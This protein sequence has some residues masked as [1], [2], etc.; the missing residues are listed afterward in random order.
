MN[1][2]SSDA[3]PLGQSLYGLR[4]P[5]S[6]LRVNAIFHYEPATKCTLCQEQV[7]VP[8]DVQV[9]ACRATEWTPQT[10]SQLQCNGR[11]EKSPPMETRNTGLAMTQGISFLP[12][13]ATTLVRFRDSR[14]VTFVEQS[15]TR[16]CLLR[17]LRVFPCQYH[18]SSA[19][20]SFIYHRHS[21]VLATDDVIM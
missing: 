5:V 20:N 21:M 19:P 7:T 17:V 15:G 16:T 4:H 14:C 6:A 1:L 12:V 11:F 13:T 9:F 3:R 18:S 2:C 8:H 10:R